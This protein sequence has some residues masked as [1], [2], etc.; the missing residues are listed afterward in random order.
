MSVIEYV[1]SLE[2]RTLF[3]G[4]CPLE[5]VS[6]NHW[7]TIFSFNVSNDGSRFT[8]SFYVYTYQSLCQEYRND[9]GNATFVFKVSKSFINKSKCL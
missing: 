3:E 6:E 4:F 5:Y 1:V 2:E 9:T 7:V 8:E